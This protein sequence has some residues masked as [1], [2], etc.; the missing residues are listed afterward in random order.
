VDL[1]PLPHRDIMI[2]QP[3][4]GKCGQNSDSCTNANCVRS[5]NAY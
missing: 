3:R 1:R 5:A 4:P 2:Q